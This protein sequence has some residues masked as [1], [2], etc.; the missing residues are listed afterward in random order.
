MQWTVK[1]QDVLNWA[2]NNIAEI[3]KKYCKSQRKKS[4]ELQEGHQPCCLTLV[5]SCSVL[6][7]FELLVTGKSIAFCLDLPG[8]KIHKP[9]KEPNPVNFQQTGDDNAL[10]I[11][12]TFQNPCHKKAKD[13]SVPENSGA[14]PGS[15]RFH[16]ELDLL[17]SLHPLLF[18]WLHLA[19]ASD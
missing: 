15:P 12:P 4:S 1:A 5:F 18:T 11:C 14:R 16:W 10:E 17:L 6:T 2:G 8:F 13:F 3:T 19:T 9:E 7:L